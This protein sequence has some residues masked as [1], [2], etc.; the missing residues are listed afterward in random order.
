MPAPPYTSAIGQGQP[1]Q[2]TF[3]AQP[4]YRTPNDRLAREI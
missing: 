1:T 4:Q 3:Q 2:Q